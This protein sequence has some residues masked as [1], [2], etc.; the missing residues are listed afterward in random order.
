MT[1]H[2]AWKIAGRLTCT[3][4]LWAQPEI[5]HGPYPSTVCRRCRKRI[6]AD[7]ESFVDEVLAEAE[8]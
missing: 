5:V 3:C 8:R 6:V 7:A 4:G 2:R 1:S